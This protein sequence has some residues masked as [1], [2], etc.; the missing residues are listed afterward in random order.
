MQE[1]W[2]TIV[3]AVSHSCLGHRAGATTAATEERPLMPEL[4]GSM[5]LLLICSIACLAVSDPD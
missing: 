1:A 2:N 4:E 3:M 5:R